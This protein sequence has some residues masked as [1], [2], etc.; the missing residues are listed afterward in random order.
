M[1]EIVG[2]PKTEET[3]QMLVD[4]ELSKYLDEPCPFC[5]KNWQSVE[6]MKDETHGATY[7][8]MGVAAH[9][10][11]MNKFVDIVIL[12]RIEKQLNTETEG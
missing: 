5:G 11:C 8:R 3:V 4:F 2:I 12:R 7:I 1:S 10:D 6:E 9:R